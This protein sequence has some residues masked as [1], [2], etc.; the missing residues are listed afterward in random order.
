VQSKDFTLQTRSYF[1]R[2]VKY[3]M[4]ASDVDCTATGAVILDDSSHQTH[5]IAGDRT[6]TRR[7]VATGNGKRLGIK[8]S[9]TGPVTIYAA[10]AE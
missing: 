10:E 9:G 6:T 7:L 2:W 5:T 4:D 3:D 1:P 8:I